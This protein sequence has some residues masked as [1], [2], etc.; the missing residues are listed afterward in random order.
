MHCHIIFFQ[1][2]GKKLPDFLMTHKG[3]FG[4]FFMPVLDSS[5]QKIYQGEISDLEHLSNKKFSSKHEFRMVD[6]PHKL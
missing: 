1:V 4:M 3:L 6:L 5:P 2:I